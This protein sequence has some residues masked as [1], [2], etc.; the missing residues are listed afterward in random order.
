MTKPLLLKDCMAVYSDGKTLKNYDILINDTLIERVERG[1]DLDRSQAV[2]FDCSTCVVIPGLVN[3]HHHFYQVLTRNLP[4]AQNAKLFPW[5]VYHYDVWKHIDAEAVYNSTLAACGELLK[6]GCTCTT[7]HHYLYPAGL[8]EDIPGIQFEAASRCG[9]RFSPTRGSM[10]LSKKDGGLPP[11]SVVQDEERILED[12]E[13]T[14]NTYHDPS[15]TAMRKVVL[16]PCSPFSVTNELMRDTARLARKKKVRLHT[17]LA[18]TADETEFCLKRY[19]KR[20]LTLMEETEF[21]GPDVSYAHGIFF[22]DDELS[23]LAESGT[24]VCHCPSSNM[25]LGSGICRVKEMLERDI[26]VGIAVDGSASN[27]AS[28]MLGELRQALLLQRVKYGADALSVDDILKMG[29]GNGHAILG[30]GNLGKILPGW[31][32]DLA[33]F[34][35]NRIDYA[36]ALADPIAALLFS[37]S[38][39]MTRETI[40]NG[41]IVVEEGRL[42]GYDEEEI[43]AKVNNISAGML[44]KNNRS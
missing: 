21:I 7:D 15:P 38:C 4:R 34:D 43:T 13:N 30:F 16:A 42:L 19:G 26:T 5:L 17:H 29:T 23:L 12:S 44:E 32:A 35:L 37:G 1:I 27:D 3:T 31:T 28:D 9:I 25:R 40:V 6:T 8:V 11:D 14:I 36:G 39:H 2:V 20:P 10:S 18:E 22:N 33:V 24:A 41:K